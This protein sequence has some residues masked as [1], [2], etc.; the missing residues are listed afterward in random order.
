MK[1]PWHLWAIGVVTLFWN[2]MG[3][4]DYTMTQLQNEAYLANFSTEERAWFQSFPAWVEA[5][6]AIAVWFAVAGSILLLAR[7]RIAVPVLGISL[8]S[9][10]TNAI[11]NFVLADVTMPEVVGAEAVWFTLAIFVI[12]LATWLYARQMRQV[13]VLG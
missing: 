4:L 12:A 5:T 11:H 2:A 7:K 1:T 6:W 8:I 9:M 13:G 3:A 10:V